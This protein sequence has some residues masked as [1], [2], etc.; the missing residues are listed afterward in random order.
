MKCPLRSTKLLLQHGEGE[1]WN[2]DC[3]EEGCAWWN[4]HNN[5][6][7]VISTGRVLNYMADYIHDLKD[8]MPHE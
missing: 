7:S 5:E 2:E 3:F 1:V 4:K 8:K 6:C